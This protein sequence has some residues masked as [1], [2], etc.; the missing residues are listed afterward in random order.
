MRKRQHLLQ[1]FFIIAASIALAVAIVRYDLVQ[2]LLLHLGGGKTLVAFVAGLFFTSIA[3]T[4]PAMAVLGE[5]SLNNNLFFVAVV[6]G[7]GAVIGDYILFV[8]VRDRV[9]DDIAYLLA[10]TGTPR[11]FKI[12]HRRSFKRVLPFLG[13]LIIASPLPDELGLALLGISKM[14]TSRFL[15]I[16][17][18]FNT[19]GILL[20]GLVARSLV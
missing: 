13:G 10:R 5:L 8:F 9:S 7:A 4:A 18:A 14:P 1:D 15:A 6:G 16:S 11:F 17:F 12:F 19:V 3:T 20:I 2:L